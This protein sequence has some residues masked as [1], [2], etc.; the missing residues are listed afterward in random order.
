MEEK[1]CVAGAGMEERM[2]GPRPQ[3]AGTRTGD[4]DV[5]VDGRDR[6][7]GGWRWRPRTRG[8]RRHAIGPFH[9][10]RP[11]FVFPATVSHVSSHMQAGLGRVGPLQ[12]RLPNLGGRLQAML[13]M[14][15][16]NNNPMT[17]TTGA[18]T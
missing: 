1:C 10:S 15:Y 8:L 14:R 16:N 17:T 9:E 11:R 4:V 12:P 13:H 5:D 18:R 3:A 6:W 2:E 7:G